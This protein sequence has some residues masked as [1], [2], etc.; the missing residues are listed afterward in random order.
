M[1]DAEM[2]FQTYVAP[3]Y[4]VQQ[5]GDDRCLVALGTEKLTRPTVKSVD[6]A[7]RLLLQT[8]L[9]KSKYPDGKRTRR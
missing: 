6:F 3:A 1:A 4:E 5:V 9:P 2:D 8:P 7:I